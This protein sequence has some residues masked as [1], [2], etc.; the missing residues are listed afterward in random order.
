MILLAQ[1]FVDGIPGKKGQ[2]ALFCGIAAFA[3]SVMSGIW[4][5]TIASANAS[6]LETVERNYNVTFMDKMGFR[7]AA[8]GEQT[9]HTVVFTKGS[10]Q[11]NELEDVPLEDLAVGMVEINGN[12]ATLLVNTDSGNVE[13]YASSD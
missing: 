6:N 11:N 4:M 8:D 7:N 12:R 10:T 1:K 13:E 2:T 9:Q 3:L 5:F